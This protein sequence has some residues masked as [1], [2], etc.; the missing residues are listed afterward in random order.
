MRS[1]SIRARQHLGFDGR[2]DD[3]SMIQGNPSMS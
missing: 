3:S 2:L 1:G